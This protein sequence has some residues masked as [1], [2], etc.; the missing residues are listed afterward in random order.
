MSEPI[1]AT[2]ELD[3][4]LLDDVELEL[5]SQ[6]REACSGRVGFGA[7]LSPQMMDALR[8]RLTPAPAASRNSA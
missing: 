4:S 8:A 3:A 6:G 1:V 2:D 7:A 5:D